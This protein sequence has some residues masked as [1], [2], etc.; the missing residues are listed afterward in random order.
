MAS[1]VLSPVIYAPLT[2]VVFSLD[3]R[4]FALRLAAVERVFA[5][6]EIAS[7]PAAPRIV[8][9]VINIRGRVVPVVDVRKRFGLPTREIALSDQFIL[10]RTG[11]RSVALLVD[12]VMGVVGLS[13]D[14]TT[15]AGA[16]VPGL[17][18]V[19]GV[20]RL[21]DGMVFIHDLGTF[22]SLEETIALDVALPL[23]PAGR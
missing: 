9:G 23:S 7:L 4:R 13:Q 14:E 22:L 1:S 19:E 15:H 20:A 8:L 16:I 17:E 10:G 6:A 11:S 5:A 21:S 3:E 2:T 18:Y 12:A